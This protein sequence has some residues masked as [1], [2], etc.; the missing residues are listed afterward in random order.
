MNPNEFGKR[1]RP[2]TC[3]RESDDGITSWRRRRIFYFFLFF[4]FPISM[5]LGCSAVVWL[6]FCLLIETQNT[7]ENS[8]DM[9]FYLHDK[10]YVFAQHIVRT[11]F[12]YEPKDSLVGCFVLSWGLVWVY[13]G[14]L[15]SISVR[16]RSARTRL[17]VNWTE[18]VT[19]V[20]Y[21]QS[22]DKQ[23][24]TCNDGTYE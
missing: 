7:I 6:Y 21:S 8:N 11:D 4:I 9:F 24:C 14:T 23:N 17:T 1:P 22:R 13:S 2:V 20:S 10:C 3:S 16:L 12:L 19:R 15:C 18:R 5:R